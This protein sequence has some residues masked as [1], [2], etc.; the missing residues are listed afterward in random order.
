MV[1]P[2][3]KAKSTSWFNTRT[4]G[5]GP[6]ALALRLFPVIGRR[7]GKAAGQCAYSAEG[8]PNDRRLLDEALD[9]T[10]QQDWRH[11]QEAA[12]ANRGQ[13]IVQDE[14][15]IRPIVFVRLVPDGE[16]EIAKTA[17]DGMAQQFLQ[18]HPSGPMP[19]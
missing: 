8:P 19:R 16:V 14:L 1:L 5:A 2:P 17:L 4:R 12:H 18:M 7:L 3:R 10:P 9:P 13:V 6:F 11:D 15:V